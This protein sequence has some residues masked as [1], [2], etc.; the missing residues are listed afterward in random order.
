MAN[1]IIDTL[2]FGAVL[3]VLV[4]IV[5]FLCSIAGFLFTGNAVFVAVA[6]YAM[7]AIFWTL[8]AALVVG[9]IFTGFRGV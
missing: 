8:V 5:A 3:S 4:S 7:V 2:V 1:K 6:Q 9:P